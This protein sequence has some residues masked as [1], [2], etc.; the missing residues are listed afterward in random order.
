M[1]IDWSK[2]VTAEQKA[3]TAADNAARATEA[4][5]RAAYATE[6][7]PLLFD[8]LAERFANDPAAQQWLAARSAVK[9]RF[10]QPSAPPKSRA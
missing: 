9:A 10:P 4:A 1:T 8:F 5:R 3:A 2:L 7:D 6:A